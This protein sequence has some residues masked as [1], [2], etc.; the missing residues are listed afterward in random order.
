MVRRVAL[1]EHTSVRERKAE[2]PG[3]KVDEERQEAAKEEGIR[4]RWITHIQIMVMTDRFPRS[5]MG[6]GE[7][8]RPF[9]PRPIA[10]ATPDTSF[11]YFDPFLR[12]GKREHLC[13]MD[14]VPFLRGRFAGKRGFVFESVAT[15][16]LRIIF[17]EKTLFLVFN[18]TD[19]TN[20]T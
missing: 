1:A 4:S 7:E 6:P 11:C 2:G 15:F 19:Y 13:E 3:E 8:T 18:S 10:R 12:R 20:R 16:F 5:T 17:Q 14:H 9:R